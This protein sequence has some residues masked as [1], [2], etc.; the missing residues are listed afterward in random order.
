MPTGKIIL[1]VEDEPDMRE[2]VKEKLQKEGY[3]VLEANNGREA[4]ERVQQQWPDLVISDV[5]MPDVDGN[6][7]LKRFRQLPRGQET[8]FIVVTARVKMRD[9]FEAVQV[10]GF[11]EKPYKMADLVAKIRE[12]LARN[13]E[14]K[15]PAP[16]AGPDKTETRRLDIKLNSAMEAAVDTGMLDVKNTAG[17]D[18]RAAG[19]TLRGAGQPRRFE[20]S[21]KKKR[22]L[23][24]EDDHRIASE[25]GKY[26]LRYG[27]TVEI[28][29]NAVDCFAG[30]SE[31]HPQVIILSQV[32]GDANAV[33]LANRMKMIPAIADI[34][35]VIYREIFAGDQN[36]EMK[37][38]RITEEGRQLLAK[39]VEILGK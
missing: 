10:D 19:T 31:F 4:L 35:I 22:I 16:G 9:Y 27:F 25:I 17:D 28:V 36:G 23:L 2:L 8:P 7:F 33:E 34:P 6:T 39:V 24:A 1:L 14:G 38:F 21:V 12:L 37:N 29:D 26:F 30:A 11:F 5:L 20:Q 13:P 18:E 32:I 3:A 15:P